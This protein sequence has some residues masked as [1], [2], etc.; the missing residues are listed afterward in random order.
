MAQQLAAAGSS[1]AEEVAETEIPEVEGEETDELADEQAAADTGVDGE[2][3]EIDQDDEL[4]Q[5]RIPR[6]RLNEVLAQKKQAEDR[7][8]Q[9]EQLQQN[10][11]ALIA[12]ANALKSNGTP[13]QVAPKVDP[14]ALPEGTELFGNEELLY[15]QNKLLRGELD[16]LKQAVGGVTQFK[17]QTE[18]QRQDTEFRD[19]LSAMKASTGLDIPEVLMPEIA[20][21]TAAIFMGSQKINKPISIADATK[22]AF[23]L[24]Q[25]DNILTRAKA[26][27]YSAGVQT[28]KRQIAQG[29]VASGG[30]GPT[31]PD[32]SKMS[33]YEVALQSAKDAIA[34]AAKG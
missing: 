9:F 20:Q 30:V 15:Q 2:N 22:K 18:S 32:Y 11:D 1:P 10:P 23:Q 13:V 21:S 34:Q 5:P 7:V 4:D 33:P 14:L 28:N 24:A 6:R 16:E 26:G 27:A 12:Y 31:K 25:M 17:Q 19:T 8:Q 3:A 29:R